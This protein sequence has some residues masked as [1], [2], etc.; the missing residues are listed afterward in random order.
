MISSE[1]LDYI[2][3]ALIFAIVI[4]VFI[5]IFNNSCKNNSRET[6]ITPSA[7][8]ATQPSCNV[9]RDVVRPMDTLSM[10][11]PLSML[12]D[13]KNRDQQQVMASASCNNSI[14]AVNK[15]VQ[16][17]EEAKGKC[18]LDGT[19]F[20]DDRYIKEF[21]LAG[22]Y[23][24][25]PNEEHPTD[26]YNKQQ[27]KNYQNTVFSFPDQLNKSSSDRVDMVDKIN[28]MYVTGNNE[29]VGCS[30]G[31]PGQTIASIFDGLTQSTLDQRK[32]CL[33]PNCLIPPQI[34]LQS[35]SAVYTG[36]TPIG[37]IDT[38]YD[39]RY[40]FDGVNNGGKFYNDIEASDGVENEKYLMV[41]RSL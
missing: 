8:S 2:I 14:D 5:Q 40:E 20:A 1:I 38:G 17:K 19:P 29:L 31:K 34:D 23:N 33:N 36:T 3:L 24:C 9:L 41:A 30:S 4:N 35:K 32:N 18:P 10:G 15:L 25:R 12:D 26:E 22:M 6:M 16:I 7:T 28:E 13:S 39:W 37:T 21:V 11:A 27:L